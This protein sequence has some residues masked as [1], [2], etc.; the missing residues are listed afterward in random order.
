M[1]EDKEKIL[2]IPC[3]GIGKP[4]GTI[5]RLAAY[6]IV[7]DLLPKETD[8]VCLPLLVIGDEKTRQQVQKFPVIT[9]DGCPYKCATKSVQSSNG[10][11]AASLNVLQLYRDHIDL[12]VKS[13]VD[14]GPEGE[15]FARIVAG[16]I[17]DEIRKIKREKEECPSQSS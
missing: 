10:K 12:E 6:Y 11:L 2:I 8:T 3:S 13:V 15:K 1:E 4:S 9:I 17:L 16:K 14:P 5:A 7:E